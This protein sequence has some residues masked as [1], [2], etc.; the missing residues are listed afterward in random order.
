MARVRILDGVAAVAATALWSTAYV[1]PDAV[2]P[3]G[4]LLLV[5]GRYLLFGLCGLLVLA[6]RWKE[7][8]RIPP[9]RMLF[10]LHLGLVGYL[11]FYVCVSYAVSMAGGFVVAI[12][13]GS[14]PIFIAV[15][16]NFLEKRAP[17]RFF[18]PAVI[19]IGLGIAVVIG[20][21]SGDGT[22]PGVPL[23]AVALALLAS[24][25]WTYFVVLNAVAQRSGTDM[26][27]PSLWAALVAVGTGAGAAVLMPAALALA[28]AETFRPDVLI[29]LIAWVLWLGVIASWVGSWIWVRTAKR[30]PAALAGPLLASDPIFGA[31]LSL[32]HEGRWPTPA[33]VAGSL[34]IIA[35][36]ATCLALDR[37]TG[38][39]AERAALNSA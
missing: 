13:V 7:V 5:C 12:L 30:L 9:R 36:V 29:R 24:G 15:I 33:E 8:R 38:R 37:I 11:V 1:A 27:S 18:V 3:A 22:A 21:R 35:G 16:G 14:S 17:W 2:K 6:A 31:I 20:A 23:A 4:E 32:A 19:A 10:A 26:P 34:L 28:P 25:V 39:A